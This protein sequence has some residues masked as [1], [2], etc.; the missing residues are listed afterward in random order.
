MQFSFQKKKVRL[1]EICER[2][3]KQTRSNAW[4][5]NTSR[6]KKSFSLNGKFICEIPWFIESTSVQLFSYRESLF[7]LWLIV[8]QTYLRPEYCI[9]I[10]GFEK[11]INCI[12]LFVS[13]WWFCKLKL[14]RAL[15]INQYDYILRPIEFI[16]SR[17]IDLLCM[18]AY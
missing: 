17:G 14:L 10:F 6:R 16:W 2:K 9:T 18:H 7:Y 11:C 5:R 12:Q 13:C 3:A 15:R 4:S 8:T 1:T